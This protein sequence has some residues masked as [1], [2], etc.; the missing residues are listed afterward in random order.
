MEYQSRLTNPIEKR[1][2]KSW[3]FIHLIFDEGVSQRKLEE[4]SYFWLFK[5]KNLFLSSKLSERLCWQQDDRLHLLFT[6]ENVIIYNCLFAYVKENWASK[7]DQAKQYYM[8]TKKVLHETC[9]TSGR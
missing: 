2:L 7:K 3:N 1:I 5:P 6:F 4:K 8:I 9:T